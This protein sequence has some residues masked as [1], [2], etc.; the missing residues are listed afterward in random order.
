MQRPRRPMAT[1]RKQLR[2]TKK[3]K[4]TTT[5]SG[6]A[7]TSPLALEFDVLP[8]TGGLGRCKELCVCVRACV[9]VCVPSV[10]KCQK[11]IKT[12][13]TAWLV[14]PA[15]HCSGTTCIVFWL[16]SGQ[17]IEVTITTALL[18]AGS[19][20]TT[21]ISLRKQWQSCERQSPLKGQR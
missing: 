7:L 18:T 11:D 10:C 17:L 9:R 19:P 20:S 12:F 8:C 1:T 21:Y 13:C 2:H 3:L 16:S 5:L 15:R 6:A 14:S 4:T